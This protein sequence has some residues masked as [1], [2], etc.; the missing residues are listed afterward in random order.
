MLFKLINSHSDKLFNT[1]TSRRTDSK[2][3]IE[4]VIGNL[5]GETGSG[6]VSEL[7]TNKDDKDDKDDRINEK[8]QQ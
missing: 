4:F 6:K 3:V 1:F 7:K 8:E 5:I 2:E